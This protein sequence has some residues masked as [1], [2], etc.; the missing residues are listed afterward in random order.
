MQR[1]VLV[2]YASLMYNMTMKPVSLA[3]INLPLEIYS[4]SP[5][6][7]NFNPR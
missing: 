7:H 2:V 1:E 3:R 4:E 6:L 5:I